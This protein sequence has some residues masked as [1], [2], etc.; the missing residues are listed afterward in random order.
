[1]STLQLHSLISD[2]A[3]LQRGK[4]VVLTG[5]AAPGETVDIALGEEYAQTMADRVGSWRAELPPPPEK[6]SLHLRVSSGGAS[7]CVADLVAGEV[8][9]CSGQSNMEWPLSATDDGDALRTSLPDDKLRILTIPRRMSSEPIDDFVGCWTYATRDNAQSFSA[10]ALHFGKRLQ[11]DLQCPIGLIHVSWGGSA[12]GSW[13]PEQTISKSYPHLFE[14]LRNARKDPAHFDAAPQPYLDPGVMHEEWADPAHTDS[15]WGTMIV[16]GMWQAHGH[17]F[18]G[19]VWFRRTVNVPQQFSKRDLWLELGRLDD[20]DIAYIN[21][22][23]IGRTVG[24]NA[25]LIER[26]YRVPAG[27]IH[28]GENCIALRIFDHLGEGGFAGSRKQLRLSDP[29][30]A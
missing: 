30:T 11:K 18:N 15:D 6:T 16:P 4:P 1:M 28:P 17:E 10:V 23:E 27:L 5:K 19:A 25:H 29:G 24:E 8:W 12:I 21:G 2:H 3:V 20:F 22:V 9:I 14:R 26:R 13:L 7:I